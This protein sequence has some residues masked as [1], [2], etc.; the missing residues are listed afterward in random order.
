MTYGGVDE[1]SSPYDEVL[2]SRDMRIG[3][4]L[5]VVEECHFGFEE[6]CSY[7]DERGV[8]IGDDGS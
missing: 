2:F 1:L 8:V 4:H 7:V 6:V 3:Q 5:H